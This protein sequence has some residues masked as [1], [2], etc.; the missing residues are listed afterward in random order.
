MQYP[1]Y[2]YSPG[3]TF[4]VD[5]GDNVYT[6]TA[7]NIN[8]FRVTGLRE[9]NLPVTGG[10]PSQ[11]P[12]MRSCDIFFAPEQTVEQTIETLAIT[13]AIALIMTSL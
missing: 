10:F 2:L 1:W 7:P 6:M 11:R 3:S 9:G 13:D 8:I 12:V 4:P 5:N